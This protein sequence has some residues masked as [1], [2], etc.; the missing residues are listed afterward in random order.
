MA[1]NHQQMLLGNIPQGLVEYMPCSTG[2]CVE[3]ASPG[4][5]VFLLVIT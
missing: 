4:S 5:P 1:L 2:H 3:A